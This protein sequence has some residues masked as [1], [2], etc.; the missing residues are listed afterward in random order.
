MPNERYRILAAEDDPQLR[1]MLLEALAHEGFEACGVDNGA[2]ALAEYGSSGPYDALLL[3]DRMPHLTGRELLRELREAGEDVPVLLISG[4]CDLDDDER[5]AL[6][7]AAVL[8]KPSRMADICR[9][10]RAAIAE[11]R[12][13]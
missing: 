9:A 8:R 6:R 12:A 2:A 4:H 3:D 1:E 10:L 5:A 7:P 13:R 11:H